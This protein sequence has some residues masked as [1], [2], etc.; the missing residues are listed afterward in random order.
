VPRHD[1]DA[2]SLMAGIFFVGVALL[3]LVGA[4]TG[5]AAGWLWPALL[6]VVGVAGLVA[7]GRP[8]RAVRP[9]AD[10]NPS[11]GEPTGETG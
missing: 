8:A 6:I 10:P 3:G 5:E 9:G 2:L 1:L 4:G 11:T 7:A